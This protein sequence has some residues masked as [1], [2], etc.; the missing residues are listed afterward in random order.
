MAQWRAFHTITGMVQVSFT[1]GRTILQIVLW[2]IC[3]I[4]LQRVKLTFRA[5]EPCPMM[6]LYLCCQR[7]KGK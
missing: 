3:K 1:N 6:V 2:A 4:T 5:F 7:T